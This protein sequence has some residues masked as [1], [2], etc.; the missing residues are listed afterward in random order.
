MLILHA[1][2]IT[3]EAQNRILDDYAILVRDGVILDIAPSEDMESRY[4]KEER[5]DARGQYAMPG[6]IIAHTHFYGAFARGMAI[7]GKPA[8]DF[9]EILEKLWWKLDSALDEEAVRYSAL[10]CLADAIKHGATTL[11]D[12]HASPNAL[13]GSLDILAEAVREAGLR[14]VLSY[15]VTDRYGEEK[16]RAAV[17]ENL[18]FIRASRHDALLR[19]AFGL[20]APLTLSDS[21]LDYCREAL[22]DVSAFAGFHIHAAESIEDEWDS[23]EKTGLRAVERLHAHGILGERTILAHAVH[24]DSRETQILA[25][26]KTFVTHQPRSNMNNAVGAAPVE[27]ML[28]AGV[29]VCLGNDGFSNTP[30]AEWKAAYF[31]QKAAHRDPRRMNG[32][33]VAKMAMYHNAALAQTYFPERPIGNL[34]PGAVAD[35]ILVDYHPFTPLTPENLPW[36]ILFGFQESMVTMTMVHGKI[37]MRDRRLLTLDE[38]DIAA[39]ARDIARRVWKRVWEQD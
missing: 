32:A 9:P 15:E 28:R 38:A 13:E 16:M 5:L 36:H 19:G 39:R 18:R 23:L 14:A 3:W 12:H 21:T 25:D 4:P 8:R 30:W 35:I 22:G 2:L 26:T 1:N 7:P 29:R 24:V 6:G 17:E 33:D 37:L 27:S 11:F 31:L 34:V 10:V 20:H